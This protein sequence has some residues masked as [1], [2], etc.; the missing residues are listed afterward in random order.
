MNEPLV[1]P[2]LL[3]PLAVNFVAMVVLPARLGLSGVSVATFIAY[4]ALSGA[5]LTLAGDLRFLRSMFS[6]RDVRSYLFVR[7]VIVAIVGA[8]PF[9]VARNLAA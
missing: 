9:I 2:D 7:I 5:L 8:V 3:L 6:R 4:A 1:R